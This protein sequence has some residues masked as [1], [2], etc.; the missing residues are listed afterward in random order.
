MH[1]ISV[2]NPEIA[3]MTT[4]RELEAKKDS[5]PD[6]DV[7]AYHL[8]P[9][10]SADIVRSFS[11]VPADVDIIVQQHHERPNG[12]GF[13]RGLLFN[14]IAPLSSLFIVAHDLTQNILDKREK[15][16]LP[17]YLAENKRQLNK[18]NF[19]RV[20]SALEKVKI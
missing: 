8:H 3:K 1:D 20:I 19:K 18:G 2:T 6:H 7:K 12:S 4:L 16:S 9:A 5:F 17:V 13:P 11:E 10:K 15:F 14:Y